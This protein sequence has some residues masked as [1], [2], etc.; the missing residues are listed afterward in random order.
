LIEASGGGVIA[1]SATPEALAESIEPLLLDESKRGTIGQA[2]R[3][4]M[5]EK[6]TAEAMARNMAETFARVPPAR[7]KI[8]V[9]A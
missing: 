8:P 2:A 4:A 6:F 9:Q 7:Q 1:K 5:D 3:A